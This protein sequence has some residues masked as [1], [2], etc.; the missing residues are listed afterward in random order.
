VPPGFPPTSPLKEISMF[1]TGSIMEGFGHALLF[2][3]ICLGFLGWRFQ[4]FDKDGQV[5][6]AAKGTLVRFLGSLFTKK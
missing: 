6:N 3:M 2:L 4:Q 5:K 1:A